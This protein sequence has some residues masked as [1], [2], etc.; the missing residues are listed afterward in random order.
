M[1]DALCLC[2]EGTSGFQGCQQL[3]WRARDNAIASADETAGKLAVMIYKQKCSRVPVR[4]LQVIYVDSL[5]LYRWKST[6]RVVMEKSRDVK[7]STYTHR[8][9]VTEGQSVSQSPLAV[10]YFYSHCIHPFI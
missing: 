4:V 8:L 6:I 10:V 7:Q 3:T 5:K 9:Y 2:R 1:V